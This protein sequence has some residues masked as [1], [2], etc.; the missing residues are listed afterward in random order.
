M[1][2]RRN[3]QRALERAFEEQRSEL[4][5]KLEQAGDKAQIERELAACERL[6]ARLREMRDLP[7]Q[8]ISEKDRLLCDKII[9][10]LDRLAPRGSPFSPAR[11]QPR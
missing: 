5:E 4:L 10:V 7:P 8:P 6:Q 1:S 2:A 3:A 11:S 9:A